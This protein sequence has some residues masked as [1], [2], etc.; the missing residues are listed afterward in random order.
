[1]PGRHRAPRKHSLPRALTPQ[2]VLPTAAAATLVL[3][4][5]GA[6]MAGSAPVQLQTSQI[7]LALAQSQVSES[8][9]D[10]V[11]L[12]ERR[13][14]T[15]DQTALLQGRQQEAER[16]ARDQER[17]ALARK[18]AEEAK[19]Q[20]EAEARKAAERWVLPMSSYRYTSGFGS[21]WG[22][23]H[24]GIDLAAPVGTPIYSVSSGKVMKAGYTGACGNNV[25]VEHWD[26]TVT[27]YCHL[28]YISVGVGQRVAPGEKLGGNGNTGRS[29]GPHLHF[30]V[31]P[32]GMNGDPVDPMP[33]LRSK[34]LGL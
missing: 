18:Q 14:A 26:G 3:T 28:D 2:F 1:V 29:Y 11:A 20:A 8:R 9:D 22:R 13:N 12:A 23:L 6:S 15:T 5:T 31:R 4:T 7:D 17:E 27:R 25:W 34:G 10:T 21:R 24:A 33:W 32:G 19:K 30:E 16:I